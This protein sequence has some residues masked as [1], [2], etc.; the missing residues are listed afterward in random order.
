MKLL[1]SQLLMFRALF[2]SIALRHINLTLSVQAMLAADARVLERAVDKPYPWGDSK[3]AE[4]K[5]LMP[6][7][8]SVNIALEGAN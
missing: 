6:P 5:T 7:S 8:C 2:D 3:K 1:S 4:I